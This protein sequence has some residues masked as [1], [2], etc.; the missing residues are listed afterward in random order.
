MVLKETRG[1]KSGKMP[2]HT[3]ITNQSIELVKKTLN[4]EV[5]Q[6]LYNNR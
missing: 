6:K 2:I 1:P 4:A 3:C 5:E